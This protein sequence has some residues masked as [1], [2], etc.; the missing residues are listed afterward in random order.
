MIQIALQYCDKIIF[1]NKEYIIKN[2]KMTYLSFICMHIT[3]YK[4]NVLTYEK[5]ST[6]LDRHMHTLVNKQCNLPS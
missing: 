6:Y 3:D 5:L 2:T 1:G 4:I